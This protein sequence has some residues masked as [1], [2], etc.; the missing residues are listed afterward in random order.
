MTV[1]F[2]CP[3]CGRLLEAAAAPDKMARCPYCG[4][5]VEIPAALGRLPSPHI[6][7]GRRGRLQVTPEQSTERGQADAAEE[8]G[9]R[10]MPWVISVC[11]HLGLGLIFMFVAMIVKPPARVLSVTI[12][13]AV[14]SE[15]PG[16]VDPTRSDRPDRSSQRFRQVQASETRERNIPEDTGETDEQV[17]LIGRGAGGMPREQGDFGPRGR[18]PIF[19]G[20]PSS[21]ASC[22][23]YLID[24]SGSMID[25]FNAVRLE[26]ASS[27]ARLGARHHFHVILFAQGRV[28]EKSPPW[29]TPGTERYKLALADF[30]AS[31]RPGKQTDP[32]PAIGRAFDVLTETPCGEEKVIFLLTDGVFPDN[33]KVVETINRRNVGKQV[34][35]HT[36]LYGHRPREAEEVMRRIARENGGQYR[37]VS[38]DE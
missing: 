33:R 28:L 7:P 9:A 3:D 18:G 15:A 16:Q 6:R 8:A 27:V 2:Q 37:F 14:L 12:P 1:K 24:R 21:S 11:F 4:V 22:V 31:V 23:V 10:A 5:A 36:I 29:M 26:I 32:I 34:R 19:A 30:L 17:T 25:S 20:I 35:V 38:P 13:A